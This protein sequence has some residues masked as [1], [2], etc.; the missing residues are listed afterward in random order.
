M[1]ILQLSWY[2]LRYSKTRICG[3][4]L[5]S[6]GLIT[7]SPVGPDGILDLNEEMLE[8]SAKDRANTVEL[9]QALPGRVCL[10][11]KQGWR[12]RGRLR[13]KV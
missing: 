9:Y 6:N 1:N 11:L 4:G 13:F 3:A 10:V 8:V 2:A 5:N 7:S 12:L